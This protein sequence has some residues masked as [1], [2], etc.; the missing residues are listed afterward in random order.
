MTA[1]HVVR[2]DNG[3]Y[4]FVK[5]NLSVVIERYGEVW[6]EQEQA[7]NALASIMAELDAARVVLNAVRAVGAYAPVQICEALRKHD[8]LVDDNEKPSDWTAA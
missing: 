8:A 3:K 7:F 1:P 4:T 2:V 6:H 5:R